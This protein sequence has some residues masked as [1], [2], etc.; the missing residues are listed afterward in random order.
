[1]GGRKGAAPSATGCP[2]LASVARD[3]P[4]D[5]LDSVSSQLLLSSHTSDLGRGTSGNARTP[6]WPEK[7][8]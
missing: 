1:M 6:R 7:G 2:G 4:A 3:E 8:D 5:G